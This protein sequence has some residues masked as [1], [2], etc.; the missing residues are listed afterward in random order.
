[1]KRWISLILAA[2][3]VLSLAACGTK[4]TE[5]TAGTTAAKSTAA[6]E[7]QDET[8]E[9]EQSTGDGVAVQVPSSPERYS[10]GSGSSGGNFY[11]VGGG[12]ATL[13]NNLLPEYFVITSEETGGSTANL[14]MLQNG[15]IEFGIAMT[16]SLTEAWEGKADWTGGPMDKLRGLAALY[17]SYMTIYA[18]KDSGITTLDD[19]NGKIVG[20]GSKG[21]A[22]DSIFRE[23]L[24]AM[25]V[26]PGSIFNDGH[27]ATATAVGDGQVDAALLFTLPPFAAITELEATKE[28]S[29]VGLTEE[30]QKYLTDTYS[31]YKADVLPAGSYK[32]V[33]EDLNVVSEWNMLVTS[34]DVSEDY[35][36]LITK[37]LLE[38]NPKLVEIYKGLTYTT[39][40]NE[41]NYNIPLHAGTVKYLQEIGVEVPAELIPPEYEG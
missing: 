25:G 3:M 36:Y 9:E 21:A 35:V 27:G 37:T 11:L 8:A 20:L 2:A 26:E 29:F 39:A 5:T 33:T 1:M 40:E 28:L 15:D 4:T 38:N 24:P 17:P 6:G 41:L 32:G 19:L 13:L 22:M 34:S 18:L 16:S 31:F 7:A 12:V 10:L 30:Q 14:T 23:A